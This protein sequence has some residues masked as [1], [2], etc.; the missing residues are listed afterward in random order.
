MSQRATA[1]PWL[2]LLGAAVLALLAAGALYA[3]ITGVMRFGEIG[4]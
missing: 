4:V 2:R 1:P 3:V